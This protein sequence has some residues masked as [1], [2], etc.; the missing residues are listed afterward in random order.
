MSIP[1]RALSLTLAPAGTGLM[2]PGQSLPDHVTPENP[3]TDAMTDLSRVAAA[4]VE[5]D[6][7]LHRAEAIMKHAKV[8][9]LFVQDADQNL[10][11]LITLRDL[12][13]DRPVRY[14]ND[15]G[16]G[17]GEIRV[18]D[19][20]TPAD[21]LE[22]LSLHDVE[23][24]RIGDIIQTLKRTGRQHALV[25]EPRGKSAVIRGIFSAT[26]ISRQLGMPVETAGIAYTFAELEA[27][28]TH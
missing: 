26:R 20:M 7:S 16:V 17:F 10:L 12:K 15:V 6:A 24:A 8:R 22:T 3:A 25:V 27:A 21:R 9:L 5:P 28:L 11:G 19:I 18:A 1:Y 2:R 4:T 23:D 14:Q 13:G